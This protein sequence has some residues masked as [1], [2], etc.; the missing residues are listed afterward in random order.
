[1]QSA[2]ES[3]GRECEHESRCERERA[4]VS[5]HR[6][7]D[8][9][10][11]AMPVS[12]DLTIVITTSP[13]PSMPSTALLE[14]LLKS[15]EHVNDLHGCRAIIVC[16]GIGVVLSTDDDKPNWKCS[17]VNPK[18]VAAYEEYTSNVESLASCL[19]RPCEV[20]VLHN[21]H[22][23]GLAVEAALDLVQTPFVM[24]V[25]HDQLFLRNFDAGGVLAAMRAH[26][27]TLRYV[28]IQSRTTLRYKERV[29]HRF[30]IALDEFRVDPHLSS[31]L[32]PLLMYY[33]KPHI[34]W[35]EHLRERVYG[36][37]A[38]KTGDFVEDVL[39]RAQMEDIKANG[40]QAHG[41]YGTWVLCDDEDSPATYHL[42][43]RKVVA[44]MSPRR[45]EETAI[46]AESLP[47]TDATMWSPTNRVSIHANVPGLAAA[48]SPAPAT[49]GGAQVASVRE[50]ASAAG[51]GRFKGV[52]YRCQAKGHSF[53][54]CPLANLEAN[55]D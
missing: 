16:D 39:G 41:Q 37:G 7:R 36:N 33:D 23:C 45:C 5:E 54:F 14:A 26:P 4:R 8:R 44:D 30:G 21:R 1:M 42:S 27:A 28:G 17:K 20:V 11:A 18:H 10:R 49:A 35:T 47:Q 9:R 6:L 43:G 51:R 19:H 32:L 38:L 24:V 2:A 13:I 46:L 15:F 53:R 48:A 12:H 40:I 52:C 34:V 25:Q 55:L 31:P 3:P 29:A 50:R 22:G